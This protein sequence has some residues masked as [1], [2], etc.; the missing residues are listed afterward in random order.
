MQQA[1]APGSGWTPPRLS[2]AHRRCQGRRSPAAPRACH[3]CRPL[4]TARLAAPQAWAVTRPGKG[5]GGHGGAGPASLLLGPS[6]ERGGARRAPRALVRCE[7]PQKF[8][9]PGERPASPLRAQ[10]VQA[11]RWPPRLGPHPPTCLLGAPLIVPT[12]CQAPESPVGAQLVSAKVSG[13]L[14]ADG[15]ARHWAS[16]HPARPPASLSPDKPAI[17]WG[18]GAGATGFPG[19]SRGSTRPTASPELACRLGMTAERTQA[20]SAPGSPR[21]L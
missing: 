3:L 2:M 18:P 17:R 20:S 6:G 8:S 16:G 15:P 1:I 5:L 21:P 19:G 10:G 13:G 12:R 14:E 11:G 4:I 9:L 7:C